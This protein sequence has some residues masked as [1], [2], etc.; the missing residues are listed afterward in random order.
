M[1]GNC[2]MI[3]VGSEYCG[4]EE[5]MF[6]MEMIAAPIIGGLIGLITNGIAIRMLFRPFHP[7]K[8]GRVAVPFTPGLIPKEKPR[9]AKAI[10]KVIGDELLD[11][12]TLQKAMASENLHQV[13]NKKVD[14]VIE[15]LGHEEGTVHDFLEQ[16]G[17]SGTVDDAAEYVSSSVSDYIAE[18]IVQRNMGDTVLEYAIDEVISNLNSMVAMVAEPAIRKAQPAIAEKMNQ[19]IA[20]ECPG[21][22]KGYLDGEYSSWIDKPMKEAGIL[23]WQKKEFIKSKMWDTYL[24]ILQKRSGR[25]IERLD[26]AA[27]VEEKINELDVEYLERLIMEISRKELNALVWMGGLLGMLIGFVNLLF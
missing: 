4:Q 11:A 20:D 23:L 16:K 18:Q 6:D 9:I 3:R 26:V 25:F 19:V 10:G 22:I 21:I 5:I 8:I 24:M 2:V 15:K 14:S 13:L 1:D 12:D 7:V 17:F 27:I